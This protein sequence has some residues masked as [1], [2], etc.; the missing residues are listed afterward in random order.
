MPAYW[1]IDFESDKSKNSIREF[2]DKLAECQVAFL[3]GC[4][5]SEGLSYDESLAVHERCKLDP[6]WGRDSY[7]QDLFNFNDFSEVR[8]YWT[9]GKTAQ[10]ELIIPEDDFLFCGG[11]ISPAS[12]EYRNTAAMDSV[13]NLALKLWDKLD[14]LLVQTAWECSDVPC[15]YAELLAKGHPPQAEPFAIVNRALNPF[16]SSATEIGKNGLLVEN[17]DNWL[18]C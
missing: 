15:S 5:D 10:F 4:R 7:F 6:L 11:S 9:F 2:Y 14:L 1:S 8:G 3:K 16:C 18:F 17:S 13:K 12:K